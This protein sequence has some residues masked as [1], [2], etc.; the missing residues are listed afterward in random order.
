MTIC[1]SRPKSSYR[2]PSA[3]IRGFAHASLRPGALALLSVATI[4]ACSGFRLSC[5]AVAQSPAPAATADDHSSTEQINALAHKLLQSG[6]KANGLEGSDLAPWHLKIDLHYLGGDSPKPL[7]GAVEQWTVAPDQWRRTFTGPPGMNFSEWSVSHLEKYQSKQGHDPFDAIGANVRFA[8]AIINPLALAANIH[9]EYPMEVKRGNFGGITI[10][11][12]SV[13]DPHRYAP[14]DDAS[15]LFPTYCFDQDS[16][17]RIIVSGKTTTQ[18]DDIQVF[19]GRAVAHDVKVRQDGKLDT[20]M[21]VSLLEPLADAN[22]DRVKPD[23]AAVVQPFAIE[24]GLPRPEPVYKVAAS[25]PI[26]P[27]SLPYTGTFNIPVLIR[28]DG[29]VKILPGA[30]IDPQDL[31]D[32]IQSAVARWKYKPYLVDGQP[33]EVQY[34]V[35]YI[36]GGKSVSPSSQPFNPEWAAYTGAH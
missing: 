24:P 6:V 13:A 25:I 28:K 12:V 10:N 29:S 33:V 4:V 9:P 27:Q 1:F 31:K 23:K 30:N 3:S 34:S 20:E 14:D 5:S 2:D 21:N 26:A 11:C 19:Q 32:A 36:I 8:R 17:L 18:F 15:A 22:A 16:H 7:S 35:S